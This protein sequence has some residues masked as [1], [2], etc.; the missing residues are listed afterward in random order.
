MDIS[1]CSRSIGPS[2]PG[3]G[4]LSQTAAR[5]EAVIWLRELRPVSS[6]KQPFGGSDEQ[7]EYQRRPNN[8]AIGVEQ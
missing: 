7:T 3:F 4:D 5:V 8:Y 2:W 1:A 6:P